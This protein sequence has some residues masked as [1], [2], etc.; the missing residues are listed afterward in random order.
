MLYLVWRYDVI[1]AVKTKA[2]AY[3]GV[4]EIYWFENDELGNGIL[5]YIFQKIDLKFMDIIYS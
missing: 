5:S 4:I 3:C 2:K 1:L